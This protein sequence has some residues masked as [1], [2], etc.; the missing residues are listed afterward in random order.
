MGRVLDAFHCNINR[1]QE[2]RV[3]YIPIL[4]FF[5]PHKVLP[6]SNDK[7]DADEPKKEEL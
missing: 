1:V 7:E 6:F 5:S 2:Q 4:S 3:G